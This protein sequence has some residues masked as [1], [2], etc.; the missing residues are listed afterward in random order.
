M[1]QKRF[2]SENWD[3]YKLQE[4]YIKKLFIIKNEQKKKIMKSSSLFINEE[5][6]VDSQEKEKT[7]SLFR[8]ILLYVNN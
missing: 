8:I 1:L 4:R 5:K 3:F 7:I 2:V 6:R